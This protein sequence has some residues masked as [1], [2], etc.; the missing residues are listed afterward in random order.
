MMVIESLTGEKANF[1]SNK[2]I[3]EAFKKNGTTKNFLFNN[4]LN[5]KID[6]NNI[7]KFY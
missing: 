2:T 7:L 3:I 1:G 4:D 6:K 5:L